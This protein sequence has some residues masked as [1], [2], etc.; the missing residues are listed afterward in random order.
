[1]DYKEETWHDI[2]WE[3]EPTTIWYFELK[4]MENF[5]PYQTDTKNEKA[6]SKWRWTWNYKIERK[7]RIYENVIKA[8]KMITK[9]KYELY[10]KIEDIGKRPRDKLH[11]TEIKTKKWE[12]LFSFVWNDEYDLQKN[13]YTFLGKTVIENENVIPFLFDKK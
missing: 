1:M 8:L 11:N 12:L 9:L 3:T 2:F 13:L 10:D 6:F 4:S 7:E 5:T